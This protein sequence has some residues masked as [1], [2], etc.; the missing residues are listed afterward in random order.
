MNYVED[1]PMIG[2]KKPVSQN[3]DGFITWTEKD[4]EDHYKCWV[5]HTFKRVEYGV[6]LYAGLCRGDTI[7]IG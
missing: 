4:I 2:V 7:R 5:K 6:L 3:K 1:D